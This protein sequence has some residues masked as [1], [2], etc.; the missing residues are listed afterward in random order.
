M[1]IGRCGPLCLPET[2]SGLLWACLSPVLTFALLEDAVSRSS[3]I[4]VGDCALAYLGVT[5]V[6]AQLRLLSGS[7]KDKDAEILA[8]RH[9][10]AVLQRQLGARKSRF[11]PARSGAAAAAKP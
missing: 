5:D 8:L 3:P 2:S 10:I 6:V 11:E 9:Q 7:D 1:R 4:V